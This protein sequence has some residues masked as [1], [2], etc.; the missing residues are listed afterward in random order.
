MEGSGRFV[1]LDL[2]LSPEA[3]DYVSYYES[4]YGISTSIQPQDDFPDAGHFFSLVSGYNV[5]IYLTPTVIK[6]DNSLRSIPA[7]ERN[8]F[9]PDEVKKKMKE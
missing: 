8:C 2:L 1:A 3:N 6:S 7:T 4:F 5:D 9:F